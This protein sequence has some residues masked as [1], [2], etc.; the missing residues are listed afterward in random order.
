[1]NRRVPG[2]AWNAASSRPDARPQDVCCLPSLPRLLP[3]ADLPDQR[4][5]QQRRTKP[6]A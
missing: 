1:M 5:G 4:I 6:A 3:C 2:G